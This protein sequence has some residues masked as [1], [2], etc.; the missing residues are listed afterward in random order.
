LTSSTGAGAAA[1]SGVDIT[2]A[3]KRREIST[4][5]DGEQ[6]GEGEDEYIQTKVLSGR[7][8]KRF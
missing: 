3:G 2:G 8:R 4:R 7:E 1:T 6:G 5:E